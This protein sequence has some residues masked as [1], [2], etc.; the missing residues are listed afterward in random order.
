MIS[1]DRMLMAAN[2]HDCAQTMADLADPQKGVVEK[3]EAF[4]RLQT[5]PMNCKSLLEGYAREAQHYLARLARIKEEEQYAL[6]NEANA[7]AIH[8]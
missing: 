8:A 1:F 4:E 6:N 5:C 3:R 7:F 2:N